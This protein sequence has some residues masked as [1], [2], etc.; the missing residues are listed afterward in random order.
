MDAAF[1]SDETIQAL[2]R[3]FVGTS[4]TPSTRLMTIWPPNWKANSARGSRLRPLSSALFSAAAPSASE[5]LVGSRLLPKAGTTAVW[6]TATATRMKMA[7]RRKHRDKV[8]FRC[9]PRWRTLEKVKHPAQKEAMETRARSQRSGWL[10]WRWAAPRARKIVLPGG[11]RL[12]RS[13]CHGGGRGKEW[14]DWLPVCIEAKVPVAL[15]AT[16]SQRPET[17]LQARTGR[18]VCARWTSSRRRDAQLC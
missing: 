2:V 3:K 11:G 17:V 9:G 15:K 18:S 8:S 1:L 13:V 10:A 7:C 5:M 14:V 12:V 6:A 4:F 16:L